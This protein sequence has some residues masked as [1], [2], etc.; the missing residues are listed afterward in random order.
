MPSGVQ[1]MVRLSPIG[2]EH[3]CRQLSVSSVLLKEV[4]KRDKPHLNIGI[5]HIDNIQNVACYIIEF[6]QAP[7]VMLITERQH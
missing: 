3:C 5:I 4:F 7:L 6:F 2:S 1:S